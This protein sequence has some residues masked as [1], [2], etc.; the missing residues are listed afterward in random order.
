MNFTPEQHD[1]IFLDG[2]LIVMAGAGSG[3]TRVLVERYLRL[4][5]ERGRAA[6]EGMLPSGWASSILA[7]TFTDKAAR[8]MRDRVRTTVEQRA[9]AAPP[10]ERPFWEELRAAVEAARIG[11]IHGFCATLLRHQPAETGLDPHFTVLDEADSAVLLAESVDSALSEAIS[12]PTTVFEEFSPHELQTILLTLVK[13]GSN[14]RAALEGLPDSPDAL[15]NNW[16][17]RLETLRT[18]V[19]EEMCSH[20]SWRQALATLHQL[21]AEAPPDDHIG[22]QVWQLAAAFP[23]S[24]PPGTL[25]F[26]RLDRINLQGGSKSAWPGGADDLKAA[27]E[28]LRTLRE[29]YRSHQSLLDATPGSALEQRAAQVTLDLARLYRMVQEHYTR[30]KAIREALDFDDLVRRTRELL[31]TCPSVRFRWQAELSAVLVDEFQ[32]TD[33]EQR[34]I[35]YALTGLACPPQPPPDRPAT[36]RPSATLRCWRWQTVYLPLPWGRCE[37]FSPGRN[38]PAG[39][40]GAGSA[41]E[42]LL[43]LPR[44]APRMG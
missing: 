35:I 1:A 40:A 6:P 30:R 14:V 43:P 2:N 22:N 12:T 18:A 44:T 13:G 36:S 42:H 34:A 8:E 25:P 38:G 3:K 21:V 11:T 29:T 23:L 17:E 41:H 7:I 28:A 16:R 4:L 9:R 24:Q 26:S 33:D 31:E 39:P 27:R 32:D 19:V 37:R 5:V 10:T 15:L 20:P